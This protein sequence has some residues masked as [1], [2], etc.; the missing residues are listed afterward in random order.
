MNSRPDLVASVSS[1]G[2]SKKKE[3]PVSDD[4]DIEPVVAKPKKKV[5]PNFRPNFKGKKAAVDSD[6]EDEGRDDEDDASSSKEKQK[7]KPSAKEKK[8][9]K[10]LVEEEEK[11][12]EQG[13]LRKVRRVVKT[14]KGKNARGYEGEPS[15]RVAVFTLR[16]GS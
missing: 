8:V 13:R 4:S 15:F 1:A 3:I 11:R 16:S 9:K 14:V 2:S 10:E 6:D 5:V 12:D 7:P